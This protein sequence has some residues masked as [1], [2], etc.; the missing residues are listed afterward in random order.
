MEFPGK[1]PSKFVIKKN[2]FSWLIQW[3]LV[4]AAIG[5]LA[6][7]YPDSAFLNLAWWGCASCFTMGLIAMVGF[8]M[9][10]NKAAKAIE[11]QLREVAKQAERDDSD[12]IDVEF[13]DVNRDRPQL[14]ALD[15]EHEDVQKNTDSGRAPGEDEDSQES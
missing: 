9:F 4:F 5:W 8:Y 2:F 10:M 1:G 12:V 7:K 11:S 15:V 14:T 13:D 3:V 6:N